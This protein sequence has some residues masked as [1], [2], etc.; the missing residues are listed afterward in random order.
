MIT[1]VSEMAD[2]KPWSTKRRMKE[3][4]ARLVAARRTR[5]SG[6]SG[7]A[8]VNSSLAEPDTSNIA[9]STL[10]SGSIS[11]EHREDPRPLQA[12]AD[13]SEGM[14]VIEEPDVSSDKYKNE[15]DT[16][17]DER[18]QGRIHLGFSRSTTDECWQFS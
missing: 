1:E 16:F 3:R 11:L 4:S 14:T 8:A 5:A 10:S 7:Q 15:D 17:D 2:R 18:A 9:A 12:S 13:P 6:E